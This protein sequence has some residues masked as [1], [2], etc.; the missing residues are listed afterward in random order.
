M[1]N[2]LPFA[3]QLGSYDW[4]QARLGFPLDGVKVGVLLGHGRQPLQ[5]LAAQ[6][7]IG[8]FLDAVSEP[9]FQ[10]ATVIGGRIGVKQLAPAG[11]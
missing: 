4:P 7:A 8:Q 6:P 2:A 1:F 10:K 5:G 3:D 9:A 11:L